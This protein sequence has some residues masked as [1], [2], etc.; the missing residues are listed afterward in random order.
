MVVIFSGRRPVGRPKYN[1]W[2]D[3][4]AED[5]RELEAMNLLKTAKDG[6]S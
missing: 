2:K 5:L 6:A 4:V 1:R 3:E